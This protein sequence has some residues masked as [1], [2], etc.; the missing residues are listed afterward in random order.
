V[1]GWLQAYTDLHHRPEPKQRR[2]P[3]SFRAPGER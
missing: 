1:R 3:A 2:R